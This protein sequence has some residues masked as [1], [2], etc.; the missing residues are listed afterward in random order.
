[1]AGRRETV[2]PLLPP[3]REG[4]FQIH[5]AARHR[6]H[7]A[8]VTPA[9]RKGG[10]GGEKPRGTRC[11][12]LAAD[13]GDAET[14]AVGTPHE[15]TAELELAFGWV[16]ADET[17]GRGFASCP[18]PSRPHPLA[19]SLR[20]RVPGNASGPNRYFTPRLCPRGQR[21]LAARVSRAIAGPP[22]Y[23]PMPS[24]QRQIHEVIIPRPSYTRTSSSRTGPGLTSP[25][26]ASSGG[27]PWA[28]PPP[29]LPNSDAGGKSPTEERVQGRGDG[30]AC[31]S[32]SMFLGGRVL[33]PST[34]LG[35]TPEGDGSEPLPRARLCLSQ[36]GR[37]P[38]T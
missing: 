9:P 27:P 23:P 36:K 32:R 31:P 17:C 30:D 33:D 34:G 19:W 6:L 38:R 22:I 16:A 28:P 4:L 2:A 25:R 11:C 15:G 10:W 13:G 1:M 5:H 37:N 24:C 35:N 14:V 7:N 26:C 3:Q 12:R 20:P 18:V 21:C 29:C 8:N